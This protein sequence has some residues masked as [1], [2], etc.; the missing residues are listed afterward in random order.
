MI[1]LKKRVLLNLVYYMPDH[2]NLVQEFIW[3]T[4]DIVPDLPRI[5][6]F[7]KF[8]KNNIDAPIQEVKVSYSN[9]YKEQIIRNV[10]LYK[11]H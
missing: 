8:W 10:S 3:Q 2:K 7:L 5:H 11:W 9:N 4:K 1:I 6:K